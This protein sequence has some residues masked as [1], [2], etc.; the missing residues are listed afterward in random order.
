MRSSICPS[1]G[2]TSISGSSSPVGLISC[3]AVTPPDLSSSYA[4]GVADTTRAEEGCCQYDYFFPEKGT[5]SGSFRALS[6]DEMKDGSTQI[7][8]MLK[9]SGEGQTV[10][11]EAEGEVR[12]VKIT[13]VAYSGYFYDL[14]QLWSC[15]GL[16]DSAL[17]LMTDIP[18]GMPNLKITWRDADG[19]QARYLTQSGEDG[20]LI[21]M[22]VDSVEAVG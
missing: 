14:A 12:D 21:L 19:Q 8:D 13:S 17:Q 16:K 4:A 2:L 20:S 22:P 18:D 7:V 6:V 3:S 5:A 1:V 11:L 10:Y 9:V 15:S